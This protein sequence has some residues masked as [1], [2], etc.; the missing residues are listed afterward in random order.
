LNDEG[1]KKENLLM[2]ML[3]LKERKKLRKRSLGPF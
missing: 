3:E 1:L 2:M